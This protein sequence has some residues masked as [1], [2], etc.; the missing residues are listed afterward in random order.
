MRRLACL[1]FEWASRRGRVRA[2]EAWEAHAEGCSDC[3][4]RLTRQQE[5]S[6]AAPALRKTWET[7]SLWP[8]I[9]KALAAEARRPSAAAVESGEPPRRQPRLVWL[10]LAAGAALFLIATVGLQVFRGSL[11]ERELLTARNLPREP[12]L[13]EATLAEVENSER[14]YVR[15]I[16]DLSRLAEPHL[17]NSDSALLV[18]Y[19]EKL[20][21]LDSAI[22]DLRAQLEQNRFNTH[23]RREL[24]TVYQE[25]QRTLEQ[26]VKEVKS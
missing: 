4:E 12:L 5:I 16:E 2:A 10:P 24:L 20:L 1:W 14:T 11:G 23:L 22:G 21:L 17:K 19:R 26:V 9:E 7:P 6:R 18:N 15:A 3:R 13:T 25:K 8:R